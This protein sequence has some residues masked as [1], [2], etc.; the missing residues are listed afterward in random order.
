MIAFFNTKV[1]LYFHQVVGARNQA[2]V[3]NCTLR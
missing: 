1:A 2:I 3:S